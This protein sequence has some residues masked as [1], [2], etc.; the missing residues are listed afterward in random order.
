MKQTRS[1]PSM[2]R[3]HIRIR[4]AVMAL[5]G[6][7]GCMVGPNY[8]RP[9]ADVS[10]AWLDIKNSKQDKVSEDGRWWNTFEDPIL[11]ALVDRALAR[12]LTLRQAGLRVIQARAIRGIAVGQF[13]PQSQTAMGQVS[14]NRVSK[15]SPLGSGNRSY[16]DYSLGLQAA[17]ELD[18]WGKFRRGIESADA[19]LDASVADFDSI[20]VVLTSDVASNYVQIRSLQEE[21]NY[22]RA[23]VKPL[24]TSNRLYRHSF[25][26][27]RK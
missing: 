2:S 21:L 20:L 16:N 27:V 15:N 19:S 24:L 6:I 11:S 4:A 9:K 26:V 18:F 10:D 1:K 5:I 14:N 17:W 8:S 3:R 23:N 7:T 13:F 22:T 25:E 12:N